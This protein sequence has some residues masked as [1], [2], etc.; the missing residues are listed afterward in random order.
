MKSAP[1]T[2]SGSGQ[3]GE[4]RPIP[5]NE[6][7]VQAEDTSEMGIGESTA[8]PRAPSANTRRRIVVKTEPM[9]VTTQEAA[10]GFCE[11]AMRI[12]SAERVELGNIMELSITGQVLKWARRS[13]LSWRLSLRKA[14]G[15]NLKN[16]SHLTV[17]KHLR[18]KTH[19]SM[20]VVTTGAVEERRICSIVKD[21]IEERSVVVI[22]LNKESAIWRNASMKTLLRND[23]LRY[24]DVEGMRVVTNNRCIAEQIKSDMVESVVM[25]G[26]NFGEFGK[27]GRE[28][29]LKSVVMRCV[30]KNSSIGGVEDQNIDRSKPQRVLFNHAHRRVTCIL[31]CKRPTGLCWYV[32]PKGRSKQLGA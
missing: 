7:R 26:S 12:A 27:V 1:S 19:C 23:Q 9:A 15:C 31:P 3:Q 4:K 16:H 17:A 6:T 8:L 29:N 21:Q 24:I 11:K 30:C 2:A 10:V 32:W 20:L 13:N 14:D 28:H 25:G 18:E 5:D 22:V